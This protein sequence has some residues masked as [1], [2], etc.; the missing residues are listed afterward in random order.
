MPTENKEEDN[1][2]RTMMLYACPSIV[3]FKMLCACIW[4]ILLSQYYSTCL[5]CGMGANLIMLFIPFYLYRYVRIMTKQCVRQQNIIH[6]NPKRNNVKNKL[7]FSRSTSDIRYK[8]TL[9][10]DT[11][12]TC[13]SAIKW[14]FGYC[15][16]R[17]GEQT[18]AHSDLANVQTGWIWGCILQFV[19]K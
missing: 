18:G 13:Y 17:V 14:E 11:C 1:S 12:D 6:T 8:G 10:L 5:F 3:V 15:S 16:C 9:L 7:Q 4:S 2:M 19:G